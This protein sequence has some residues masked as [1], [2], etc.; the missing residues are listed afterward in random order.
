VPWKEI[1]EVCRTTGGT[2]WFIVEHETG[3][4]PLASVR[5]CLVKLRGQIP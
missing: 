3:T 1:L 2:E 5:T 4:D